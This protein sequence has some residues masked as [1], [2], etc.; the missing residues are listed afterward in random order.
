MSRNTAT[1]VGF[2]ALSL[3]VAGCSGSG[4]GGSKRSSSTAAASTSASSLFGGGTGATAIGSQGRSGVYSVTGS[5]PTRGAYTGQLELTWT[6]AGYTFIRDVEFTTFRSG[7]RPVSTVWTGTALDDGAGGVTLAL[8][9][10]RM[11]W[12]QEAHGIPKRTQADGIPMLVSAQFNVSGADLAGAYVGQGAP[13]ADPS[14][15]WT[16]TGPN[17]VA[18]IWVNER[19]LKPSHDPP[20]ALA[21]AAL[22]LAFR[23]FHQVPYIVPYVQRPEFQAAQYGFVFDRTDF[24]LHRSRPDLLR[25]INTL[26]DPLNLEEALVKTNAFGKTLLQK[27]READ[28]DVVANY[29]EPTGVLAQV[30]NGLMVEDNDGALWSGYYAY[31]QAMRY[32]VTGDQAAKDNVETFGR[33]LRTA[34]VITG[35]DDEFARTLRTSRGLPLGTRWV[36]GTGAY[37]GIEWKKGGN[38]DMYK[39]L[40]W[41]GLALATVNSPLKADFG[42][43]LNRL[44]HNHSVTQGTRRIGNRLISNGVVSVLIGPGPERDKYKSLTRNPFLTAYNLAAGGGFHYQGISDWSGTQLNI[45]GLITEARLAEMHGYTYAKHVTRLALRRAAKSG[46]KT[47][48]VLHQIAG[49]G[50]GTV[51]YATP[52]DGSD[53]VWALIEKPFPRTQMGSGDFLR[54]DYCVGPYP[55][56]P[57]KRDWTTNRGRS[58]GMVGPPHFETASTNFSWKDSP[59]T[60][61]FGSGASGEYSASTDYLFGYWLGRMYGVIGPND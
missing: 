43:A 36:A 49:A 4:S 31:S 18:P 9:L 24:A 11:G 42:A 15:T 44:N 17:G 19:T 47:R 38:N 33:G 21:K 16:Y 2:V 45:S 40:L 35:R 10:N 6:G 46:V 54:D 41:A 37:A 58:V 60:Q 28:L 25:C 30:R 1:S 14:E 59:Y 55:N 26:V 50:L 12:A 51:S 34:M 20:S 22:F 29:V 3:L 13:F 56:L 27:A 32:Q 61:L 5:D 39:G 48:R 53:G 23:S 7:G 52:I 57:W 8:K